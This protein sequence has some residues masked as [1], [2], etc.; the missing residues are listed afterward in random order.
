MLCQRS[1]KESFENLLKAVDSSRSCTVYHGVGGCNF[2]L[3][4]VIIFFTVEWGN[5]ISTS[6]RFFPDSVTEALVTRG[7]VKSEFMFSEAYSLSCYLCWH[8]L[9][10]HVVVSVFFSKSLLSSPLLPSILLSFC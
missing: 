6:F 9:S 7:K 4:F 3:M 1:S 2:N 5:F 8:Y 10:L